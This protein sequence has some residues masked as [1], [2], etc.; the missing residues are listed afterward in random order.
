MW[1]INDLPFEFAIRA[2]AFEILS[3]SAAVGSEL[4]ISV[5]VI[6]VISVVVVASTWPGSVCIPRRLCICRCLGSTRWGVV[7]IVVGHH[8]EMRR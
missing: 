5:S 2:L 1:T 3:S 7:S 6:S 4:A 8:L